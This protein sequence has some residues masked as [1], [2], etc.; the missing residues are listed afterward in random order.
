[1]PPKVPSIHE[2][3]RQDVHPLIRPKIPSTYRHFCPHDQSLVAVIGSEAS[4]AAD[5]HRD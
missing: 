5:H 4:E 1:M 3:A 2:V